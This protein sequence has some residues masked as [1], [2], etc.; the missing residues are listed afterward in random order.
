MLQ[1]P[2]GPSW[3]L[4]EHPASAAPCMTDRLSPASL[5]PGKTGTGHR[6]Q[7]P[8]G[9]GG[10]GDPRSSEQTEGSAPEP[11][12]CSAGRGHVRSPGHVII[13]AVPPP[14]DCTVSHS[15]LRHCPTAL[16]TGC[17][18]AGPPGAVIKYPANAQGSQNHVWKHLFVQALRPLLLTLGR[19]GVALGPRCVRGSSS[20]HTTPQTSPTSCSQKRAPQ[21]EVTAG[22][23]GGPA[24]CRPD[25]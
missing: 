4:Q 19:A 2:D 1:G 11:P 21:R 20:W 10:P 17:H 6:K 7:V 9:C 13:N 16:G 15:W 25:V 24:L 23:G 22:G 5:S 14:P 18:H 8:S 12:S 3:C